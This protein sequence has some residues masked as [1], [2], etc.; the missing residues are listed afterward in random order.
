[1]SPLYFLKILV[2]IF[3]D[4][5]IISDDNDI[6][7]DDTIFRLNFLKNSVYYINDKYKC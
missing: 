4:N 2:I 3:D 1:M 6:V 7:F 5:D